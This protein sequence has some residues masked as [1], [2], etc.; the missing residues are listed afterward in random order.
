MKERSAV[1]VEISELPPGKGS[2]SSPRKDSTSSACRK[3]LSEHVKEQSV[4]RIQ[5]V[6]TETPAATVPKVSNAMPCNALGGLCKRLE[7]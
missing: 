4:A 2:T 3:C 1:D 7:R 5:D 6:R